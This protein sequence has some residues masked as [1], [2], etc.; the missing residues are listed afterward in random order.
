MTKIIIYAFI[1]LNFLL[2]L[3]C[4]AG[5]NTKGLKAKGLFSHQTKY[6]RRIAICVGINKYSAFKG[7]GKHCSDLKTAVL[8]AKRMAAL[9]S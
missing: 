1:V 8:D 6:R 9:I 3:P 7:K 5:E 4:I 2:S